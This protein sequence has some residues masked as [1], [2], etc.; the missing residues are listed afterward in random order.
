MKY[1]ILFLLLM[2]SSGSFAQLI[3]RT[4]SEPMPSRQVH[5]DFHTSEFIPG[6]GE[7]FDKKQFQETLKTGRLNQ[8]NI[9]SKCHHSWSYYPTKIGQQHPNLKFDLVGAQIEACHEIGVK[10]PI[11]YSVGWSASEAAEHPDW[12]IGRAHV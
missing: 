1:H 2:I 7:K 9:F 6:I 12:E 4:T 10:C 5:L 11:Y 8:I 3:Q